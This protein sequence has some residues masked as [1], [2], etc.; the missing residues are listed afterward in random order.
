MWDTYSGDILHSFPHDHIVR[1][2]A[3]STNATHLLTGGHEKK[4]RLFDLS[5]PDADPAL[6]VDPS[7]GGTDL[8][9][10][11]TVKSVVWVDDRTGVSGGEDGIVKYVVFLHA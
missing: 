10:G 2:V 7:A 5:R 1:T 8:A 6:L 11:G 9:H 4:V 3:L